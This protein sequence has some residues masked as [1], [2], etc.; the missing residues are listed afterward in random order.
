MTFYINNK[1]VT[2]S[3]LCDEYNNSIFNCTCNDKN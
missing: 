3:L 2:C 1:I